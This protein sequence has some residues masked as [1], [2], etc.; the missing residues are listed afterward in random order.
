MKPACVVYVEMNY[1]L[2]FNQFAHMLQT[3]K[4]YI[5]SFWQRDATSR[6]S[7]KPTLA[8]ASQKCNLIFAN[9]KNHKLK[10]FL[11][12]PRIR[13]M[14][15]AVVK[16]RIQSKRQQH[17]TRLRLQ[18]FGRLIE[19]LW[20]TLCDEQ[21]AHTTAEELQISTALC[22]CVCRGINKHHS[23]VMIVRLL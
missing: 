4:K 9:L 21:T 8:P 5:H 2:L 16:A 12:L 11:F 3:P 15:G 13:C 10:L 14:T 17:M 18:M 7:M 20:R 22:V 23:S 19:R 1:L 6:L